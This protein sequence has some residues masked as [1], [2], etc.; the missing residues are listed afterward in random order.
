MG[1][2]QPYFYGI[3]YRHLTVYFPVNSPGV[4]MTFF[5]LLDG[6]RRYGIV[7]YVFEHTTFCGA[8]GLTF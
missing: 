4:V 5:L 7:W 3:C 2:K 8:E 1:A 6:V